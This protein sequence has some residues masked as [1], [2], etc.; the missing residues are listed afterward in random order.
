MYKPAGGA[1]RTL[2][3]HVGRPKLPGGRRGIQV[4]VAAFEAARRGQRHHHL[5][6]VDHLHLGAGG[7][8]RSQK[9]LFLDADAR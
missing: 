8:Q 2:Q 3:H 1:E 6:V 9:Q 4:S 7:F 5:A